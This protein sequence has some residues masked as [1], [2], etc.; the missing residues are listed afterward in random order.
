MPRKTG[1]FASWT[2]RPTREG[3]RLSL[4]NA[5]GNARKDPGV[6]FSDSDIFAK[7]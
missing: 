5:L 4:S 7:I 6:V 3:Y 2:L 1:R